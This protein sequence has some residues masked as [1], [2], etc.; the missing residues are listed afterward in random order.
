[1][2]EIMYPGT[3]LVFTYGDY[4]GSEDYIDGEGRVVASVYEM[5]TEEGVVFESEYM[6]TDFAVDI[7]FPYEDGL[8]IAEENRIVTFFKST[9]VPTLF[10]NYEIFMEDC[11][12]V[13]AT[14]PLSVM[15]LGKKCTF[16]TQSLVKDEGF[17]DSFVTK[18]GFRLSE[19]SRVGLS[20]RLII[21][22]FELSSTDRPMYADPQDVINFLG[23]TDKNGKIIVVAEYTNPS[24]STLASRIVEAE[25]WFENS[26]RRPFTERRVINEIDNAE[27]AQSLT[28]PYAGIFAGLTDGA[29]GSFFKGIPVKL[30][31]THVLPIDNS[32]GD[33]VEVRRYGSTWTEVD[34]D[35]VWLDSTRGILYI[36]S[37]F[38]QND[39]SVRVTYRCGTGPVPPD[40]KRIIILKTAILFVQTD[41][42]R[43][44]FPMAPEFS[45]S[46]GDVV[47]MW[48]DELEKLMRPYTS[49]F[50]VGGL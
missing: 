29:G 34:D 37:L 27:L 33:K 9:Q 45:P 1:M 50:T 2:S 32:K 4:T 38:F 10:K 15:D 22:N 44:N 36:K 47:A 13:R 49:I 23:V 28:A 3:E 20:L 39:A 7:F 21:S 5:T 43:A 30:R 19:P 12:G 6:D 48:E 14:Y 40:V 41:W 26:S 35:R 17:N 18:I 11:N 16:L 42:Y 31:Y 8:S 24:Y 25:A 46:K